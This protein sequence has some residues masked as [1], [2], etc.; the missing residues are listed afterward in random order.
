[1]GVADELEKLSTLHDSGELSDEEYARAKDAV[2]SG[3]EQSSN[4]EPGLVDGLFGGD[5]QSLGNAANRYVNLQIVMG[6]IGLL[7][8]LVFACTIMSNWNTAPRFGP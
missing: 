3:T 7:F 2:L 6:V 8:F 1:M 4:A 5:Q